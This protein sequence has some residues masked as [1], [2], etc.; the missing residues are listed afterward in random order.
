M[1]ERAIVASDVGFRVGDATL[2]AGVDLEVGAGEWVAVIGPNG[3]GKSTLLALVAGD[4]RPT[5]GSI[6]LLGFDVAAT[7]VADLARA[8]AMLSQRLPVDIPFTAREVVGMGRHPHRATEGNTR[9]NDER[10]VAEAMRLTD[11]ERFA[12]RVYATLSGGERTRVSL[13]RVLA[14]DTPV[15]LLDEPTTALD[16]ANQQR[17][18]RVIDDVVRQG[19][20]VVTVMHDLNVAAVHAE[21]LV[22]MDEGRVVANGPPRSVLDA[23]LLSN[24]YGETMTVVP[25][26]FHDVPLVLPGAPPGNDDRQPAGD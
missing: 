15:V 7:P 19:K 11:T 8:R 12:A 23:D 1:P 25:H 3:A 6:A 9:S 16:I 5:S 18:M 17:I 21:R 14:Q 24:V 26:P 10:V 13:A 2:V 22:L 4:L 20:A